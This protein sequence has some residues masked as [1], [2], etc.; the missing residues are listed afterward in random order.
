MGR[1]K[2]DYRFLIGKKLGKL[3]V[4]RILDETSKRG[5]SQTECI[6]ECGKKKIINAHHIEEGALVSCGCWKIG[7]ERATPTFMKKIEKTEG[8]WIW[9]GQINKAGYGRHCCKYAHRLSYQYH[10]GEISGDKMICHKCNNKICVNPDHMYL[11][12]AYDNAQDAI[13]DGIYKKRS[14][15]SKRYLKNSGKQ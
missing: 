14:L 8:C 5:Q 12:T 7:K 9:K 15:T 4:L 3:T 2:K 10:V 6:C 1:P 11:G 13:R